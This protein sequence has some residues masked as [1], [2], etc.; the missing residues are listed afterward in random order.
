M[1]L[2]LLTWYDVSDYVS[3]LKRLFL[4]KITQTIISQVYLNKLQVANIEFL[5][6]IKKQYPRYRKEFIEKDLLSKDVVLEIS[7]TF[8]KKLDKMVTT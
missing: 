5:I 1:F 6:S 2:M 3:K 7:K 4:L 8:M